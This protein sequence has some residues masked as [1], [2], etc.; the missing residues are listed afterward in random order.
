[1]DPPPSPSPPPQTPAHPSIQYVQCVLVVWGWKARRPVAIY[2]HERP[3][4]RRRHRSWILLWT[5][6][7]YEPKAKCPYS[8]IYHTYRRGGYWIACCYCLHSP[9]MYMRSLEM[10]CSHSTVIIAWTMR[11]TFIHIIYTNKIIIVISTLA[12]KYT[13]NQHMQET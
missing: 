5:L 3:P 8:Y 2:H 9:N 11:F 12:T 10:F 13:K 4:R 7:L 6:T 1:M